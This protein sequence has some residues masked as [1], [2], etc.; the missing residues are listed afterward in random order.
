MG[1]SFVTVPEGFVDALAGRLPECTLVPAKPGYDTERVVFNSVFD[2]V[3]PAAIVKPTNV[4]EIQTAIAIAREYGGH[5]TIRSGGHSFTGMSTGQ[6]IVLDLA[7]LSSV[8]LDLDARTATI[9]AGTR[10]VDV[11][12]A[13]DGTGLAIPSGTCPTVGV[14]G[15]V[16]GGGIGMLTR[17]Y[18]LTCDSLRSLSMVTAEGD[19]VRANHDE[20]EDLFWAC[21]GGGGGTLGVVTS[22]EFDLHPVQTP[23]TRFDLVWPWGQR[24]QVFRH[25]QEWST[26]APRHTTGTFKF[27]T[28]GATDATPGIAVDGVFM[29]TP[30]DAERFI[31]DLVHRI[32]RAPSAR[33][34]EVTDYV[35]AEKDEFYPNMTLDQWRIQNER[36]V[37]Q[38]D[39]WGLS[40]KSDFQ[41]AA[42][43]DEAVDAISESI[44]RRQADPLLTFGDP[45]SNLGKVWL[46]A[47]GGA[48]T[49]VTPGDTAFRHRSAR[50]VAQFQSRWDS[51][52][53]REVAKANIEWLREFY[54]AMAP[55]RSG[56]SYLNYADQDDAVGERNYFGDNTQRL[57]DTADHYDPEGIFGTTVLD[58]P[59]V[60]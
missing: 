13:I 38:L 41:H 15:L 51:S 20:N 43:P 33:M 53:P 10:M 25:W 2:V 16:L 48:V 14:A 21:R 9:G 59:A 52:A 36:P 46:E 37:D 4:E 57:K 49:D 24:A 6:G 12:L 40:I 26:A 29:G 34:T 54:A 18:G 32:G 58:R 5:L 3:R 39:R 35:D 22:F 28:T 11:T 50:N 42:W 1:S 7:A 55:W 47:M 56:N 60:R 17:M 23:F 19:I 45:G 44:E 8:E 30:E 31:E 27:T